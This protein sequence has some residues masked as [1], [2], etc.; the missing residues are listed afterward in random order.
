V[1]AAGTYRECVRPARGGSSPDRMISY[2]AAPGATVI[3]KASE[4]F[5][6]AGTISAG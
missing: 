2:E 3:V 5:A 1:I 6:T 4:C